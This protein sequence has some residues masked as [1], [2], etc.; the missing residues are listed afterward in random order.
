SCDTSTTTSQPNFV[1]KS[2]TSLGDALPPNTRTNSASTWERSSGDNGANGIAISRP[3]KHDERLESKAQEIF[4][5]HGVRSFRKSGLL[6]MRAAGA[7]WRRAAAHKSGVWTNILASGGC[8][9][10]RMLSCIVWMKSGT[11]S[12]RPANAVATIAARRGT[13]GKP[14]AAAAAM[15][16]RK[17]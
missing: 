10:E 9:G 14:A 3:A 11:L 7:A 16:I 13:F 6:A 8:R 15:T 5:G 1:A 17:I 4:T 12:V 2:C